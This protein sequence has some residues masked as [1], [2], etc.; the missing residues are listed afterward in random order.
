VVDP[1]G[2]VLVDPLPLCGTV[3]MLPL[4]EVVMVPFEVVPGERVPLL[5]GVVVIAPGVVVDV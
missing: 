5:L 1:V 2:G 4:G 3:V